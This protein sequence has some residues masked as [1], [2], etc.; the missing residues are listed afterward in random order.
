MDNSKRLE[1]LIHLQTTT[2]LPVKVVYLKRDIRGNM[3][4]F[5]KHGQRFWPMLLKYVIY[6]RAMQRYIRRP[7]V[8]AI[9]VDYSRLC[10]SPESEL[11]R[12]ARFLDIA[13]ISYPD[14]VRSER[15]HVLSGNMGTRNQSL[16]AS[17][18]LRYDDSWK[19]RLSLFQKSVL[20][21]INATK[22]NKQ[23]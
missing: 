13:P 17:A 18:V 3:A 2:D 22:K 11:E 7:E 21:F 4:L 14:G 15:Y 23:T 5:L 6:N 16:A 20:H 1:R 8:D 9:R 12:M 19:S 10:Q